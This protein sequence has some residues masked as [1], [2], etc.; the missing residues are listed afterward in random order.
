MIRE[1]RIERVCDEREEREN[2][3]RENEEKEVRWERRNERENMMRE[4]V[5]DREGMR[6]NNERKW[7]REK[8]G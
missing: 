1:N 6:E 4:T 5:D 3:L 8:E 7:M 2:A